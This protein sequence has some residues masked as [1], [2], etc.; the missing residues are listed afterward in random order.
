MHNLNLVLERIE[1]PLLDHLHREMLEV[2]QCIVKDKSEDPWWE[3]PLLLLI[4][5]YIIIEGE[6][7]LVL[8]DDGV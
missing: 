4:W 3:L 8:S 5:G 1:Y 7:F 2:D 6:Q